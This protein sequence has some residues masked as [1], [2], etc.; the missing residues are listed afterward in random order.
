MN[1]KLER[2]LKERSEIAI[3]ILELQVDRKRVNNHISQV[4]SDIRKKKV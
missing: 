4:R 1:T 2:L 3:A